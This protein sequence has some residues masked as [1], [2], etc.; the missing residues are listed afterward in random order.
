MA[1]TALPDAAA[2]CVKAPLP[3]AISRMLALG[4]SAAWIHA[5]SL[6]HAVNAPTV[7]L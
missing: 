1:N 3:A 4:G 7:D 2:H 6:Y 5:C